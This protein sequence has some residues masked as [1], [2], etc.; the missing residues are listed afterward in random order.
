MELAFMFL[1]SLAEPGRLALIGLVMI[2]GAVLLRK[3]SFRAHP[4]LNSTP[5]VGV[6]GD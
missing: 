1:D 5:N 2:L 6:Q 3:T 4:H